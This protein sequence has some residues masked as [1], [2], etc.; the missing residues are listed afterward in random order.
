MINKCFFVGRLVRDL[1]LRCTPSGLKVTYFNLAVDT[2]KE[3]TDFP[4][5][6]AWRDNAERMTS[7]L[8][9]GDMICV[10]CHASTRSYD[11]DGRKVYV[12]EFIVDRFVTVPKPKTQPEAPV[13]EPV[14]A[15]P[16][17]HQTTLGGPAF[18][19]EHESRMDNPLTID[20][21]D[22]DDLPFY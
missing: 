3:H 11:K 6:V 2:Y 12:T 5:L 7:W 16:E 8:K 18:H 22:S 15:E 9:K 17:Y 19:D 1:E 21:I 13:N 14:Q 10:E 4:T 20:D